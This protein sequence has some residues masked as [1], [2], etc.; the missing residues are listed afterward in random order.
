MPLTASPSIGS[1]ASDDGSTDNNAA[2]AI[3]SVILYDSYAGNDG[4]R[5]EYYALLSRLIG[6]RRTAS[7]AQAMFGREPVLVG[8]LETRRAQ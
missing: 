4:H 5:A 8:E 2:A 3:D 6:A 1:N 7:L